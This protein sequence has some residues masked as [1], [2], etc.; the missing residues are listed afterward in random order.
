MEPRSTASDPPEQQKSRHAPLLPAEGVLAHLAP[1]GAVASALQRF[2]ERA[3]QLAMLEAVTRAFN[4]AEVLAVEA[5][6]GTGKSLAY[7]LPAVLWSQRSGERVVVSTYTI[8]LQQQLAAR[9]I[10]LLTEA[11]GLKCAVALV[12]GRGNYL[13]LRKAA[14]VE[15]QGAMLLDDDVRAQLDA[16]LNWAKTTREGSLHE[17]AVPPPASAWQEVASEADNCL[18]ARCPFYAQ[19]Y[20]YAARRKAAEAGLLIVNH[21]LLLADLA[22]REQAAD[23]V[24]SAVLPPCHRVVIDEAHHLEDVA[25]AHFGYRLSRRAAENA[26]GRLQRSGDERRGIL[27][28]LLYALRAAAADAPKAARW[29]EERLLAERHSLARELRAGFEAVTAALD[30]LPI[31]DGGPEKKVRVTASVR[32][33]RYWRELSRELSALALRLS[34]YGDNLAHALA[35]IEPLAEEGEKEILFLSA[36]LAAVRT[37]LEAFAAGLIEFLEGGAGLCCWLAAEGPSGGGEVALHAAPIDVGGHLRRVLFDRYPT[38]VL[39][40]AT[41]AVDGQMDYFQRRCG[42]LDLAVPE[43]SRALVLPSPFDFPRQALFAVP[44]D[45]PDPTDCGF[46]PAAHEF[47]VQLLH[48][49]A[50]GAFVLFT[51]YA[52]L[53][54]AWTALRDPLEAAGLRPL[55]QGAA[56]RHVLLQEFRGQAWSVLFATD[57]FWEGVDVPGPALRLVVIARLPFAVPTEPVQQARLEAIAARGGSPFAEYAVPQ[58]ALKLKQG[59]GRLIRSR[60][61]RG[62]VVLLDGRLA[63]KPYGHRFLAS[64]PP[65]RCL[66]ANRETVLAEVRRFFAAAGSSEVTAAEEAS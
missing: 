61:D 37:R 44:D 22:L 26:L 14:Q 18:R 56:S 32:G 29:I 64:L 49:T 4:D 1:G 34:G 40:S 5:G 43:R 47:L 8:H 24:H 15:T 51:S 33:T 57:S 38:V 52:A 53:E 17:L 46:E 13:C 63:R 3:P 11:A 35:C 65:A 9:D 66:L 30:G 36:E 25:T 23:S 28:A 41:L 58:A 48:A 55:R 12:K 10:P 54:S 19:C 20:F 2:E 21:H 60:T 42:L 7:L 27:P 31:D 59:F 50:G 45:L 16:I 6:T 39:T 62:A